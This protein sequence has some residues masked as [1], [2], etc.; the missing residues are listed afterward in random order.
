VV[1]IRN[2][3]YV[4]LN[5]RYQPRF[6]WPTYVGA[7]T[8]ERPEF[9]RPLRSRW[10]KAPSPR[11]GV[12]YE[13]L[14]GVDVSSSQTQIIASFVGIEAL[15]R[16]AS[17][18][19]FKTLMA[20]EAWRRHE[21]SK[22]EFHLAVPARGDAVEPYAGAHDARLEQLCKTLWMQICYG[23][24]ELESV[25]HQHQ[26]PLTYGPGWTVTNA[27]RFK[28]GLFERY[29]GV[30]QFLRACLEICHI[31]SRRD[32][33]AAVSLTDPLDRIEFRWNPIEREKR[34]HRHG[35][36]KLEVKLPPAYKPGC[37]RYPV[38]EAALRRRLAP[39]VIHMLDAYFSS[40]VMT[41]L[42][43]RGVRDLVGI[44]DC[45]LVPA[46]MGTERGIER[47]TDLIA[48]ARDTAAEAWYRGLG[49]VFES[50]RG[51]LDDEGS[52]FRGWISGVHANWEKRAQEGYRPA[53]RTKLEV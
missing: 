43:R 27:S 49:P 11:L 44:H 10:F 47:A 30:D 37:T 33:C 13:D 52:R 28:R 17:E 46:H 35:P 39:C 29:R 22:D 2:Q 12:P 25:R 20:E 38:D 19:S 34:E 48:A 23:S 51:Y 53:F 16:D 18:R 45:W 42:S 9:F 15:E 41:E 36:H 4:L 26:H 5:R 1:P 14:V 24:T 6:L 32:P 31:A 21:D 40:L 50:M 7:E 8:G 3:F